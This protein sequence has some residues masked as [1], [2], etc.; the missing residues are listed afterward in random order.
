MDCL[1]ITYESYGI[2]GSNEHIAQLYFSVISVV[3]RLLTQMS[4]N[5]DHLVG[6]LTWIR[7]HCV[8]G[9]IDAFPRNTPCPNTPPPPPQIFYPTWD[10]PLLEPSIL[11]KIFETARGNFS[12][13]LFTVW[14]VLFRLEKMSLNR[15]IGDSQRGSYEEGASPWC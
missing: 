12:E 1:L 11:T 14:R 4:N 13:K 7:R 5:R 3:N 8:D 15:S 2:A 9:Q 6:R 10:L